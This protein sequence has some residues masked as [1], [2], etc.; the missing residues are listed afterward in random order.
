MIAE[1]E[2]ARSKHR[3]SLS[4]KDAIHQMLQTADTTGSYY[5]HSNRIANA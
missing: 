5:R 1:V 3:I 4:F 2:D